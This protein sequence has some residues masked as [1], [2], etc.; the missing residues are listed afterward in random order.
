MYEVL[1]IHKKVWT[2]AHSIKCK[3][4]VYLLSSKYMYKLLETCMM[5]FLL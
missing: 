3:K 5:H 4:K 2:E 1:K